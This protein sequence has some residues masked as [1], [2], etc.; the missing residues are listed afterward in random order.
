MIDN[1]EFPQARLQEME[2]NEIVIQGNLNSLMNED[3]LGFGMS[4]SP[5]QGPLPQD[6]TRMT[7]GKLPQDTTRITSNHLPQE[8]TL[9]MREPRPQETHMNQGLLHQGT[10][11]TRTG[12]VPRDMVHMK[13]DSN[14]GKM[15]RIFG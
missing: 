11:H 3:K 2:L 8:I 5:A 4:R 7:S 14:A 9:M 6:T 15:T 13:K 12:Q 1:Q 10:I